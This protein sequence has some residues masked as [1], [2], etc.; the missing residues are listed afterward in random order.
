MFGCLQSELV[1]TA[2]LYKDMCMPVCVTYNSG[3]GYLDIPSPTTNKLANKYC[4]WFLLRLVSAI[5]TVA[6]WHRGTS[7][8]FVV[9]L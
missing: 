3:H 2:Y 1:K 5:C 9:L 8:T 6:P 4:A 7:C